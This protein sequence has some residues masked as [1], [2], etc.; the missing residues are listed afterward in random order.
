MI[1]HGNR[2]II[3]YRDKTMKDNVVTGFILTSGNRDKTKQDDNI[4]RICTYTVI[5]GKWQLPL[6]NQFYIY[7]YSFYQ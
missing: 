2:I 4:K 7:Q 6:T 3:G 1:I 5:L